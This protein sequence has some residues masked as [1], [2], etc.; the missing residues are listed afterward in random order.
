MIL[1]LLLIKQMVLQIIFNLYT[2]VH[3]SKRAAAGDKLPS[4]QACTEA[5][6]IRPRAFCVARHSSSTGPRSF[7]M[8]SS[9]A[10][11]EK[12]NSANTSADVELTERRSTWRG[13]KSHR[14]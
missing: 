12:A 9:E 11:V 14:L 8:S 5:V 3:S 10:R 1:K 6:E 4:A 7:W 2:Q 13:W